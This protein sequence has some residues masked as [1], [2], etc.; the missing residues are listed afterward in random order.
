M[1][2][3][4]FGVDMSEAEAALYEAPFEYVREHVR[5]E[6]VGNKRAAYAERWWLHVEARSGMRKALARLP[7][8]LATPNLTKHRMFAWLDASVLP[9]HQII[10]IARDDDYTFGVLH[11]RVHEAW[12]RAMGTQLREVESGFRYTPTTCFETFPFPRPTDA[13]RDF[14][15]H[16]ARELDDRRNGWLNPT[17]LWDADL[18]K[19]TLTNLYNLRPSWLAQ[20]HDRLDVAVLAAYGWPA[21]IGRDDLLSRLLDLNLTRASD[22]TAGT[23]EDG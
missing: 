7:R 16:V 12:A 4:D 21:D 9:D 23:E 5:P 8:Y 22:Q 15:A 18:A 10:V 19:Q 6:R 14:I 11:S 13:Q 3:I 2:I 20:L 1:W 17:G